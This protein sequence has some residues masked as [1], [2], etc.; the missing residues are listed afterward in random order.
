MKRRRGAIRTGVVVPAEIEFRDREANV[1]L[2]AS[3]AA[4]KP[5]GGEPGALIWHEP[6]NES[7]ADPPQ[8]D[9][10][11]ATL[12]PGIDY[13]EAW[14]QLL[15]LATA[16]LFLDIVVRRVTFNPAKAA[17]PLTQRLL[18][19]A[20]PP[21]ATRLIA[22]LRRQ[23]ES[24]QAELSQRA[25]RV[26]YDAVDDGQTAQADEP[27]D[28]PGPRVPTPPTAWSGLEEDDSYTSR[29]LK[30][31]RSVQERRPTPREGR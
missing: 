21:E 26:R 20:A 5:A 31:K 15:M 2:L 14:P 1:A 3:L 10:F 6:L 12:A 30:A 19:R 18:R 8:L 11:R 23:K 13:R 28:T 7:P 17:A 22:R 29:L 25:D 27:A 16:L 4:Q 9:T 24:V